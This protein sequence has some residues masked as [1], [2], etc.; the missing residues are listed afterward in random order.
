MQVSAGLLIVSLAVVESLLV[1]LYPYTK[2]ASR[3]FVALLS[4]FVFVA[5]FVVSLIGLLTQ[6]GAR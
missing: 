6:L 1:L 4:A 5:V 3:K 2:G